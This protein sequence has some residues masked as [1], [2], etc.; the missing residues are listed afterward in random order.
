[1]LII[2]LNWIYI[3]FISSI[4]GILFCSLFNI[5][6]C[7]SVIR[8]L[9]GLFFYGL[10]IS[11]CAFF[12]RIHLE[13][14]IVSFLLS[15]A[16]LLRYFKAFKLHIYELKQ[17][18]L[19]FKLAYKF[20]WVFILL[21]SLAQSS[22]LP[23]LLDN[24]TYY[25]QTIK[26]LNEYGYVKGLA[27]LHMFLGQN[28]S[29]HAI[30]AGFN[31]SFTN[32]L[33][34]DLNSFLFVLMSFLFIE[35]LQQYSTN[36][37]LSYFSLGATLFCS[38]FFMQFISAPSPDLL[39]FLVVPYIFFIFIENF[40]RIT[41]DLFKI[42]FS[43]SVFLCFVK[44]TM[45]ILLLLPLI[46]FVRNFKLLKA[47]IVYFLSISALSLIL[48]VSKNLIISGYP[49]YPL[50]LFSFVNFDW[51]V[52]SEI[53]EVYKLGTYLDGMSNTD[54]SQLSF[55]EKIKIW[56]FLPKLDGLFNKSYVL[57]LLIFPISIWYR[58]N[59]VPYIIIYFLAL[60]QLLILWSASPQYR[61]YFVFVAFMSIELYSQVIRTNFLK[62][63][64]IFLLVIIATIPVFLPIDLNRFT[65]NKFVMQL[66]SFQLKNVIIPENV[67]KTRT[68][69]T[70]TILEDFEFYSPEDDIYF[71]TT[72]N[73]NLPCV[74]KKQI[75]YFRT[76]YY[77]IP[78]QRS[79]DL[80]DGFR[81][82]Y[83]NTN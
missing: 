2:L 70:K 48:F 18:F 66:N 29:W 35:K 62:I 36:Q 40:K 13:F 46:L 19:N 78:E 59:R 45:A 10:I 44:V 47:D 57:L 6:K 54:T 69:F 65:N 34:N 30:Q 25:I 37:T 17:S 64:S 8:M 80:A 61:F 51:K 22:T 41:R 56:L 28:S 50:K 3:F 24:E 1:M 58:K 32:T 55:F 9:L 71:W 73:G 68:N 43:L 53:I 83:L 67:S 20:L 77:I 79:N 38:I 16:F 31:F 11:I 27:N 72:G 76:Y 49:L 82:K 60:A 63:A 15:I 4:C 42:I 26:W 7:P 14:F 52:P 81:V 33:L 23:Y 12:I 75:E 39:I 5:K 21:V 74:N